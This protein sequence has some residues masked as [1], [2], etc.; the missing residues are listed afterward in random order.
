MCQ[1]WAFLAI[2]FIYFYYAHISL[3]CN[4]LFTLHLSIVAVVVFYSMFT[5]LFHFNLHCLNRLGLPIYHRF[6]LSLN[7]KGGKRLKCAPQWSKPVLPFESVYSAKSNR[8]IFFHIGTGLRSGIVVA[9]PRS[10]FLLSPTVW[11]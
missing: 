8:F 7:N 9:V 3:P 5:V 10:S 1:I 4:F 2:S 11:S 6:L